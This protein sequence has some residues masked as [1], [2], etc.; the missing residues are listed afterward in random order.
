MNLNADTL[1][2]VAL[3]I[4]LSAAC[5]FRIFLPLFAL[6]AA[7]L[8]GVVTLSTDLSWLGTL[9]ALIAFGTA[10]SVEV[11]GYYMPW[12]DNI[13]DAIATPAA[14]I[15]GVIATASVIADLPPLVRWGCALI[16]G[17]GIAG[18][19]QGST[20]VMRLHSSSLTGGLG[21]IL[22]STFENFAALVTILLALFL[23]LLCLGLIGIVLVWIFRRGGR[24]ISGRSRKD[25][26]P[27]PQDS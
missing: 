10:T 27:T 22:L 17:G 24:F 12:L 7:S 18:I 3:G 11:M 5:G 2:S 8:V 25:N 1:T 19:I 26:S 21:N 9:P 14:V 20:V 4:G 23:P 16:G 13:L 15:A 6:S